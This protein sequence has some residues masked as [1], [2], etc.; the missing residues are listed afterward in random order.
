MIVGWSDVTSA[1]ALRLVSA[2]GLREGA[3]APVVPPER[4]AYVSYCG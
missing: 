2:Y 4:P 1:Q 3:L